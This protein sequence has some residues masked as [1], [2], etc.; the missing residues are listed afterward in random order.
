M[1]KEDLILVNDFCENH[2]IEISFIRSLEETGLIGI[3]TVENDSYIDPGQLQ[4]LEKIVRL[5]YD[6]DINLEGIETIKY[7]MQRMNDLQDEINDLK[8]RLRFYEEEPL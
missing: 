8:N 5:H 1:N 3:I 7:L 4:D 6:L 2:H